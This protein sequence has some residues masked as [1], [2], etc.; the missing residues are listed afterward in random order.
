MDNGPIGVLGRR[1]EPAPASL[2]GPRR[3]AGRVQGV[4]ESRGGA[5]R[6]LRYRDLP[7][8]AQWVLPFAVA[9]ALVVALVVWV[10][11]QTN[12]VPQVANVTNKNAIVEQNRED[13]IIVKQQQRPHVAKLAPGE[14]AGAGLRRAVLGYMS[15]QIAHS[16]IDGPLKGVS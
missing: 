1:C 8:W 5:G 16:V 14:S 4:N 12:D 15:S 11:H 13:T 3:Y 10:H 9:A 7:L 2:P 6:R